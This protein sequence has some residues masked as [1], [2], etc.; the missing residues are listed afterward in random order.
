MIPMIITYL[1][2]LT[3]ICIL[4]LFAASEKEGPKQETREDPNGTD[5]I[6][7]Q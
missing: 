4:I 1:V 7:Y 2:L 3:V 6:Y 5:H